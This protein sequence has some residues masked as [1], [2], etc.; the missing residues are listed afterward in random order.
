MRVFLSIG[1]LLRHN[2]DMSSYVFSFR[3]LHPFFVVRTKLNIRRYPLTFPGGFSYN[4]EMLSQLRD[5]EQPDPDFPD[6][7]PPPGLRSYASP[8][9][10]FRPAPAGDRFELPPMLFRT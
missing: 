2:F 3:T 8:R 5:G 9:T 7:L 6:K 4:L 1:N 10:V